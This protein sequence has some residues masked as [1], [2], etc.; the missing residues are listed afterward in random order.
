MHSWLPVPA[1]WKH[2]VVTPSS[3]PHSN[4]LAE[5]F[6]SLR[7][8]RSNL[9]GRMAQSRRR[10]HSDLLSHGDTVHTNSMLAHRHSVPNEAVAW[11]E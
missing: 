2:L 6:T 3:T 8:D 7:Y 1:S 10:A 4:F 11:T 9:G 5:K